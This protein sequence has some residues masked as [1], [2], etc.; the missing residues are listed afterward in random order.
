[1]CQEASTGESGEL[2]IGIC[3]TWRELL[4]GIC[5]TWRE[6]DRLVI[7]LWPHLASVSMA[8]IG[9]ERSI[10]VA[11]RCQ[12]FSSSHIR[13]VS[14]TI[15]F[16]YWWVVSVVLLVILIIII[17]KKWLGLN[18]ILHSWKLTWSGWWRIAVKYLS[19]SERLWTVPSGSFLVLKVFT[20][21]EIY[22][23]RFALFH[24]GASW[25]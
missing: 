15:F 8:E 7:L 11:C 21:F 12:V 1:M 16:S 10:P 3:T 20:K 17:F 25:F 4:I 18:I 22:S 24:Q 14:E 13:L 23:A 5:K 9:A 2:S 19:G 6:L